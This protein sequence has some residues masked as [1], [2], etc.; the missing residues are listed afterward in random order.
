MEE[1]TSRARLQA[2]S[3]GNR[4]DRVPV[5]A[6]AGAYAARMSGI[7]LLRYYT[8]ADTCF[9]CQLLSAEVH[10]YDDGPRYGWA[11]WGGWEF[12]GRIS[13]P[14]D[15]SH[16]APEVSPIAIDRPQDI[17][18]VKVP[19]P[20]TAG[21]NP[22]LL[23]FNRLCRSQGYPAK[24]PGGT[25]TTYVGS[26]IGK[27]K[28]LRWY[29]REPSALSIAYEKAVQFILATADM[30]I[31]EF[32][33]SNCSVSFVA[34]LESNDLIS[35]EHFE[36]F[37]LSYLIKV[38]EALKQRGIPRFS[39]HI[40]GNHMQ[41]LPLWSRVELPARSTISVGSQMDIA[42]V[43]ESFRHRHIIAGNVP[44]TVLATGSFDDVQTQARSCLEKYKDL[45]GG[46]ILM[47]ECEL[48]LLTPPANVYA[49]LKAARTWGR[50]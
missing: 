5:M 41:N 48:P 12:G 8:D 4:S 17:E 15:Y 11:D 40:C 36:K 26:I 14:R 29:Q 16:F 47:P 27:E 32:G 34:P 43:A 39:L 46:Y 9:K 42:K 37:G 1:M 31:E 22:I 18:N 2:V 21:A 6:Y 24:I 3:Q 25:V 19:D 38:V 44:T 7:D 23:R 35:P 13:F 45:P 10:G 33:A 30:M 28:S 49:M 20:R 50:Y